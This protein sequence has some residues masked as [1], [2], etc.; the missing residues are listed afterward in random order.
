MSWRVSGELWKGCLICVFVCCSLIVNGLP[1]ERAVTI[2]F[3]KDFEFGACLSIAWSSGRMQ[4]F[5]MVSM[6][7]RTP[8][9]T[10][11]FHNNSLSGL[12]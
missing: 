2:G 3:Q 11:S 9:V 1:E 6:L 8:I 10:E 5:P 4:H 7:D 12:Y